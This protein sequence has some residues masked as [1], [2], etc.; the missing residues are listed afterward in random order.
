[1]WSGH[2]RTHQWDVRLHNYGM[3][4]SNRTILLSPADIR[5]QGTFGMKDSEAGGKIPLVI[6]EAATAFSNVAGGDVGLLHVNCEGCEYEMLE[7][8]IRAGLHW[9]METI[10][11]GSHYFPEVDQLTQ[12]YC[13]IRAESSSA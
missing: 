1:M 8:V 13:A 11:F 12:R 7:S 3:G 9:R 4:D 5:G 2:V 10:Q 6:V